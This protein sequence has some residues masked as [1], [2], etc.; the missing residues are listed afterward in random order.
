MDLVK[1]GVVEW[2]KVYLGPRNAFQKVANC[3]YA[4][5]L[6][7]DSFR[8]SLV[9]IAGKDLQDAI[10]KLILAL[11]WQLMRHHVI[12]LLSNLSGAEGRMLSEADVVAWANSMVAG[13]P[14]VAPIA[15][16]KDGSI[17]SG[18]FLLHLI[19]AIQP[20]ALDVS[21]I[22]TGRMAEEKVLNAKYAISCARRLGCMVFLLHE[23]IVECKPKMLLVFV[24]QLMSLSVIK[25]TSN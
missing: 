10:L 3:N 6:G 13:K 12:T 25:Q 2:S 23:D 5:T 16:L 18:E 9:G 15:S 17:G 19:H 11:T 7:T 20:R 8:F 24:A 14:A 1:P 4:V 22:A 21:M